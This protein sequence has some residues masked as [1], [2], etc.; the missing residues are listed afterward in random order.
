MFA[1]FLLRDVG[2]YRPVRWIVGR[3]ALETT[4]QLVTRAGGQGVPV[5][6]DHGGVARTA[7]MAS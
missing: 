1:C 6:C 7:A 3:S 2:P 5:L 4:A